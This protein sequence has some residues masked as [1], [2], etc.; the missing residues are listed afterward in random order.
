MTHLTQLIVKRRRWLIFLF[1]CGTVIGAYLGAFFLRFDGNIPADQWPLFYQTLPALLAIK[2]I[3]FWRF[4]LFR[5][6]WSFISIADLVDLLKASVV[7]SG[8]FVVYV[9]FIPSILG[10][11]RA[12]FLIDWALCVLALGGA[13]VTVRAY[14]ERLTFERNS[15]G[16]R[17][18]LVGAG[19]A[20]QS[21]AREMRQSPDLHK[22][23]V[24]FI[25]DDSEKIGHRFQGLPVLGQVPS[26]REVAEKHDVELIIIAIPS[27]KRQEIQAIL[28]ECRKCLVE[29]LILPGL[30]GPV[31]G[32]LMVHQLRK[33]AVEDLIGREP[34]RIHS[35]G[36]ARD[37]AGKVVLVTGAGGSIGS[38]ICRQIASFGP[39]AIVLFERSEH[40]LYRLELELLEKFHRVCIIPVIGDVQDRGRVDYIMNLH[41]PSTVYHAAAYKHVPMMELNPLE[42]VNNNVLGTNVVA[43]LAA[44]HRAN[45]FV[46]ISTDKA[47]RPTSVMGATKRAAELVLSTI[48]SDNTVFVS[49]RF[50]NVLWSSGSVIPRFEQQIADGGPVTVT[51][52]EGTRYFM[53]IP[54]AAG[55]VL[56][57]GSMGR[58]GEI[59][60]LDMGEPVKIVDLAANMIKLSGLEPGKDIEIKFTGLRPGDKL[61]EEMSVDSERMD[62]TEHQ[63]IF[64]CRDE[65]RREGL[66]ELLEALT[67][68]ASDGD[69]FTTLNCLQNIV[70]G[71]SPRWEDPSTK[72]SQLYPG[73]RLPRS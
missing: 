53:T 22:I 30:S 52:P 8:L 38:E 9:V 16:Q 56:E 18:L 49:V 35:V 12:V 31:Q 47:V 40:N 19:V 39:E 71:Y 48:D 64:I 3:V 50:G 23:P 61:F 14:R 24:G 51:H 11:S 34:I 10:F 69:I 25:D 20:G 13:R 58:S 37:I 7:A 17:V 62:P 42:A 70:E 68:A 6:W 43:E 33:V 72:L 15:Q 1:Q 46:L 57:A 67:A 54:E 73:S 28:N 5:G 45:K 27:A 32:N 44:R 2:I 21:L 66:K 55:L 59:F 41:R 65:T 29:V 63:K 36:I 60:M 26:I 4:G